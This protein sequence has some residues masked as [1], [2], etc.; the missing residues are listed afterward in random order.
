MS[1]R[2]AHAVAA[3]KRK[4]GPHTEA[5]RP[6]VFDKINTYEDKEL[7]ELAARMHEM[8]SCGGLDVGMDVKVMTGEHDGLTGKIVSRMSGE[9]G[10]V[11]DYA[12]HAA[13]RD[14]AK[15][16][17]HPTASLSTWARSRPTSWAGRRA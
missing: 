2:N 12:P 13:C 7:T 10:V 16:L 9:Y 14:A 4:A 17:R 3:R 6:D 5:R 1:K 11:F 8:P 15:C